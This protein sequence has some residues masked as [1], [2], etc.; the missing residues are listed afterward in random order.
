MRTQMSDPVRRNVS[1]FLCFITSAYLVSCSS[2]KVSVLP[3]RDIFQV[4]RAQYQ[5]VIFLHQGEAVYRVLAFESL[6]DTTLQMVLS[7]VEAIDTTLLNSIQERPWIEKE[8]LVVHPSY[9]NPKKKS[10]SYKPKKEPTLTREVHIYLPADIPGVQTGTIKLPANAIV[11]IKAVER[12]LVRST[13]NSVAVAIGTMTTITTSIWIATIIALS[14]KSSCPYV[15]V[16]EGSESYSFQGEI[17]SGAVMR[18]AERDDYLPLP[19]AK[20]VNGELQVRI[21]N[22]LKERQYVNTAE[23]MGVAHP[24]GTQVLLDAQG[25]PR[26]LTQPL[27][28]NAALTAAGVDI[29]RQVMGKDSLFYAFDEKDA[30]QNGLTL[31]FENPSHARRGVLVLRAKNTLWF[32]QLY[33]RFAEKVG[34]RYAAFMERLEKMSREERIRQQQDQDFPLSVSVKGA[35]GNWKPGG[36][37]QMTGPMGWRDMVLPLEWEGEGAVEVRLQ[38]GFM[39][40]EVDYAAMDFS[41]GQPLST[42]VLPATAANDQNGQS[43]LR[44]IRSDDGKYLVQPVPDMYTDL[45]FRTPDLPLKD[46]VS[47]FLHAKGYYEHI[48]DFKQAPRM[49]ELALFRQP[50]YFDK[51]S[52]QEYEQRKSIVSYRYD[53]QETHK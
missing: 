37:F 7:P 32:D 39:F 50:H 26:L 15:Y 31:R 19:L 24:Q 47:Y 13:L 48:R 33:G 5:K 30:P 41:Q 21:A 9:Y 6:N 38:T 29:F 28:P 20:A 14:T 43:W 4:E 1:L 46:T 22:E 42:F 10:F 36:W 11:E 49:E 45:V 25:T 23:L 18:N 17:F 16:S 27:A 2:Y 3:S 8:S 12:D 34:I 52:R 35:D 40:W 53:Q 51:F 44:A